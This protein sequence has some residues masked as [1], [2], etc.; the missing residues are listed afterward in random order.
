MLGELTT[1]EAVGDLL[2]RNAH[3]GVVV[4]SAIRNRLFSNARG[5]MTK[6]PSQTERV[7]RKADMEQLAERTD[8]IEGFG[9]EWTRFDQT[10]LT[11]EERIAA[12]ADAAERLMRQ[13]RR[14][15]D[16]RP[17]GQ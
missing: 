17:T 15:H 5:S 7:G 10:G 2:G 6:T 8:V 13:A 12:Y 1:Y 3:F 11:E 9:D 14:E 16:Q 4:F